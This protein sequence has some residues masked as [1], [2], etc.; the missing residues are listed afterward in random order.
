MATLNRGQRVRNFMQA[1]KDAATE[2]IGTVDDLKVGFQRGHAPASEDARSLLYKFREDRGLDEP[3]QASEQVVRSGL[4]AGIRESLSG[5][6][7]KKLNDKMT[8]EGPEPQP[9]A[10]GFSDDMLRARVEHGHSIINDPYI[11]EKEI[12]KA[13][14]DNNAKINAAPGGGGVDFDAMDSLSDADMKSAVERAN[15]AVREQIAQQPLLKKIGWNA[16]SISGDLAEDRSRSLWWLLNAPQAV[17]NTAVDLT[18]G[19]FN[20]NLRTRRDIYAKDLFNAEREGLIRKVANQPLDAKTAKKLGLATEDGRGIAIPQEL[21]DGLQKS[22]SDLMEDASQWLNIDNFQEARPGVRRMFDKQ[23]NAHT[24]SQRRVNPSVLGWTGTAAGALA[25]NAGVGLMGTKGVEGAPGMTRREGYAAAGPDE[26][27]PRV[28][29][30][31]IFEVGTRYLLSRDGKLLPKDDFMLERPDV[32]GKEFGQYNAYQF[33]KELDVNP[34]DDGKLNVGV[35]KFNNDG[36]HGREVNFLGQTLSENEAGIPLL[37]AIIGTAVGG[38]IPNARQVRLRKQSSRWKAGDNATR[39]GRI[40]NIM[41]NVPEVRRK[42]WDAQQDTNPN[43]PLLKNPQIDKFT[44]GVEDFFTEINP[45][46]GRRDM[47]VAKTTGVLAAGGFA[48]VGIG[49]AIGMEREDRR[50]RESFAKRNPNVDYDLYKQNATDLINQKYQMLK[51]NPQLGGDG[52]KSRYQ[53]SRT[54]QQQVLM[55]TALEQQTLVNQITDPIIKQRAQRELDKSFE[56]LAEIDA[57]EERKG[58]RYN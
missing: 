58:Q 17:A 13:I 23:A 28:S 36:I 39:R 57:L 29:A 30:N 44:Q 4:I 32:S 53:E 35:L 41:G 15:R 45:V 46:T 16:G 49:T 48:G 22:D 5:V 42:R 24:F 34:F 11:Y 19:A 21:L 55:T 10:M 38:L 27:D 51:D 26:Q 31:A 47:N 6:K 3:S 52:G 50:R 33:S 56:D 54:A 18:L 37:G 43:A 8:M 12:A 20:P 25:V 14:K 7:S 1:L 2:N 9:N 40:K